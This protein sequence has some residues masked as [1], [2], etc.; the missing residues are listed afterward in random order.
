MLEQL[1]NHINRHNLCKTKDKILLAVSGGVDS[2]VMFHLLKDAGFQIAVAHCNFQLRGAASDADEAW[3]EDTC[4]QFKVPF[5]ARRFDTNGYATGRGVSIQMAARDLRYD[6]FGELVLTEGFDYV[7]TAHHLND[8]I[9]SILLNLVRGTGMDGLRGIAPKKDKIIRPL[10]FATRDMIIE[11]AREQGISWREDASNALDD[12]QRNFLRHQVIPKLKELNPAFEEGFRKTHERLLA[13]REFA[14]AYIE[15]IRSTACVRR[16]EN[17]MAIDIR[18]VRQSKDPAVLLW[19]MIKDLG[20]KYDQCR[21]IAGEH[22]PGKIFLSETHQLL[23]DR[24]QYFVDKKQMSIFLSQ[25]IPQGQRIVGEKT[26]MLMIKEVSQSD[27]KLVKDSAVAQLDADRIAFPLLWRRWEAGDYFVPL[28]MRSEK[29]VSDFLIDLKIPFNSKAD[30]TVLEAGGKI[31]W[32]VGHRINERYKVTPE[33]TRI[34]VIEE[35]QTS[36]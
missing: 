30:I 23:V 14:R 25:S 7:A 18:S 24:T 16:D 33:T 29:K 8:T 36:D 34:L 20:F 1:L 12:Y 9:E 35:M 2:M 22:Q 15:E 10:L 27:F 17:S 31:V 32:V 3:L 11:Y 21:K 6:F 13:A 26:R 4:R 28:G 19:E 5:Y